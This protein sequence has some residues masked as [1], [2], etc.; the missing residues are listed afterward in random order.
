MPPAA[1]DH[2]PG[3]YHHHTEYKYRR[4]DD[5]GEN[6]EVRIFMAAGDFDQKQQTDADKAGDDD[7]AANH[8]DVV[9]KK[10]GCCWRKW[11]NLAGSGRRPALVN[12]IC[13]HVS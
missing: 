11:F 2:P 1:L 7:G 10:T 4:Q 3:K 8:A 5:I 13:V 6:A 9:A 12:R